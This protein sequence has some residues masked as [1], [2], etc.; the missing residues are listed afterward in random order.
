MICYHL[1]LGRAER[2]L[3]AQGHVKMISFFPFRD[4]PLYFI[5]LNF[6]SAPISWIYLNFLYT[7]QWIHG[8]SYFQFWPLKFFFDELSAGK[9]QFPDFFRRQI[10]FES[11]LYNKLGKANVFQL[12]DEKPFS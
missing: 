1:V 2:S 12:P 8:L 10:F 5:S 11:F 7:P 6:S 9:N 4:I 3:F